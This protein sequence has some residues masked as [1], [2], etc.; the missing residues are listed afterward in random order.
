M[1][2]SIDLFGGNTGARPSSDTATV[3]LKEEESRPSI[4]GGLYEGLGTGQGLYNDLFQ[5]LW[6]LHDPFQGIFLNVNK[7]AIRFC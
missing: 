4:Y 6:T 5:V 2:L 3:Y 7:P 1:S